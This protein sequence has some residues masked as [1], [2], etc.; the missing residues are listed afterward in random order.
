M[1]NNYFTSEEQSWIESTPLSLLSETDLLKYGP[2]IKE[3]FHKRPTHK[4][5]P[6]RVENKIDSIRSE[7]DSVVRHANDLEG[8]LDDLEEELSLDE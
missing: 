7:I 1:N 4:Y 6:S 3:M 8:E 2:R 5:S